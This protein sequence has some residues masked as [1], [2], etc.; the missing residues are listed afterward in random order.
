MIKITDK[1]L[2]LGSLEGA[3][4]TVF[5]IAI[6][7]REAVYHRG[8]FGRVGKCPEIRGVL[9]YWVRTKFTAHWILHVLK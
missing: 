8:R 4:S 1:V 2:Y 9:P 7:N 3:Y 5:N 6:A